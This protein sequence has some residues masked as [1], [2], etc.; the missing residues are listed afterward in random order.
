MSRNNTVPTE[1]NQPANSSLDQESAAVK[2]NKEKY[3]KEELRRINRAW[4]QKAE[5]EK[6]KIDEDKRL[7]EL[8]KQ[9]ELARQQNFL[10]QQKLQEE[11]YQ[12]HIQQLQHHQQAGVYGT[13]YN[14]GGLVSSNRSSPP[15]YESSSN[16][17]VSPITLLQGSYNHRNSYQVMIHIFFTTYLLS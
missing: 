13:S 12:T 2:S 5:S 9:K 8:E 17:R 11:Q 10:N 3:L 15:I 14:S 16:S 7:K 4:N 1:S 6:K